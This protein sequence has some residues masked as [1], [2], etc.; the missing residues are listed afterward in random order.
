MNFVAVWVG[1]STASIMG[2]MGAMALI[3][4]QMKRTLCSNEGK[5]AYYG[6]K[7]LLRV[8]ISNGEHDNI[9]V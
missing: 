1:G 5:G 7:P 8:D 2:F 6:L 4:I 9:N 3:N